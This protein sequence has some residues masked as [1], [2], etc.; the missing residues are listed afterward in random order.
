MK[1]SSYSL[2][3]IIKPEEKSRQRMYSILPKFPLSSD[4]PVVRHIVGHSSVTPRPDNGIAM[5]MRD[6]ERYTTRVRTGMCVHSRMH[7]FC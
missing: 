6:G 7:L 1:A 3:Y 4:K 5:Q 2:V